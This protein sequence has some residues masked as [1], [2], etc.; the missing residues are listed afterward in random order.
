MEKEKKDKEI[1]REV[2][3]YYGIEYALILVV[4]T[5]I[6]IDSTLSELAGWGEVNDDQWWNLEYTDKEQ[7]LACNARKDFLWFGTY[8]MKGARMQDKYNQCELMAVT[9]INWLMEKY[10]WWRLKFLVRQTKFFI[11]VMIKTT[12]RRI[13][14]WIKKLIGRQA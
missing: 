10:P 14:Y 5:E 8:K 4:S 12:P 7:R 1:R 6:E 3:E 9:Q 13:Q 2:K 11:Y